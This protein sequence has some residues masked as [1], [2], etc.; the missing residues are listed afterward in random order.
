[1]DRLTGCFVHSAEVGV[2]EE[3]CNALVTAVLL[4]D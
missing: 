3:K 4:I 1:M 2:T